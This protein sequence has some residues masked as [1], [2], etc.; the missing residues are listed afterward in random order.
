[1]V[2]AIADDVVA[3]VAELPADGKSLR[4]ND[5]E[6]GT[7]LVR[8]SVDRVGSGLG[9]TAARERDVGSDA[10]GVVVLGK[11]KGSSAQGSVEHVDGRDLV[12][13]RDERLAVVALG[14]VGSIGCNLVV[15]EPL[16]QRTIA[17]AEEAGIVDGSERP[18]TADGQKP[19]DAAGVALV[20]LY[21][22]GS[23]SYG[24][25]T[26]A[27]GTTCAEAHTGL[28]EAESL[29]AIA[30][31]ST[32]KCLVGSTVVEDGLRERRSGESDRACN[33]V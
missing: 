10:R 7:L 15:V 28:E 29:E 22:F 27:D 16:V 32:D 11:V 18:G 3:K 2:V 33:E 6:Q 19:T 9:Q 25:C 31:D 5:V 26:L 4:A 23:R 21:I 8:S 12:L 30:E 24:E 14:N 13:G 17:E 1:M 20:A